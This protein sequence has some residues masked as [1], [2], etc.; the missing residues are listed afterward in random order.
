MVSKNFIL[1][2]WFP[3]RDLEGL[4]NCFLQKLNLSNI[5]E[6]TDINII[7]IYCYST[8]NNFLNIS[9]IIIYYEYAIIFKKTIQIRRIYLVLFYKAG[10]T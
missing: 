3:F 2:F 8:D 10:E 4:V 6:E 9:I 1:N 7:R 5:L